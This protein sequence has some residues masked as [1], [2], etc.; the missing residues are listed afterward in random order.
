M[1]DSSCSPEIQQKLIG[2]SP[3]AVASSIPGQPFDYSWRIENWR[4]L[5]DI[6]ISPPF[7]VDGLKFYMKTNIPTQP[8]QFFR[9]GSFW[10]SSHQ[11]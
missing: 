1:K 5:K 6:A 2:N 9:L 7:Y 4:E 8:S 11:A 3:G 10:I